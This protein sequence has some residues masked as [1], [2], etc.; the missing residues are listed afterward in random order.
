VDELPPA[1]ST[2]TPKVVDGSAIVC[3]ASVAVL[4]CHHRTLKPDS[5]DYHADDLAAP[6]SRSGVTFAPTA[7][8]AADIMYQPWCLQTAVARLT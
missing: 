1:R 7:D 5:R 8:D 4:G 2:P 3:A 6:R